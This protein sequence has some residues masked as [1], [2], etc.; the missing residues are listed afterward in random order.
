MEMEGSQMA[1]C[2]LNCYGLEDPLKRYSGVSDSLRF[3]QYFIWVWELGLNTLNGCARTGRRFC[4]V[5]GIMTHLH[6]GFRM[7]D[8]EDG[9]QEFR[10]F[11][12][13][14]TPTISYSFATGRL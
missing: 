2:R 9:E 3:F 14:R 11:L 1:K 10:R 13:Y 8:G 5:T 6:E 12:F 7:G 4:Y